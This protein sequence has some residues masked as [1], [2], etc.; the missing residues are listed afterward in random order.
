MANKTQ[1]YIINENDKTPANT[2]YT[3]EVDHKPYESSTSLVNAEI[4]AQ[5]KKPVEIIVKYRIA[6]DS[7]SKE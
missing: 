2:N 4:Y 6:H 7:N 5:E 1:K 3:I